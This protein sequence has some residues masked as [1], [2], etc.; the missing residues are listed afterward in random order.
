MAKMSEIKGRLVNA[1]RER[2]EIVNVNIILDY[3]CGYIYL[4]RYA[5]TRKRRAGTTFDREAEVYR[6]VVEGIMTHSRCTRYV[7]RVRGGH[8]R[9]ACAAAY[10]RAPHE[11]S[12][13]HMYTRSR[14]NQA[15]AE[16]KRKFLLRRNGGNEENEENEDWEDEKEGLQ[17]KGVETR[18]RFFSAVRREW[19]KRDVNR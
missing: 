18:R 7:T 2:E 14:D 13:T 16:S 6:R 9:V 11:H 3:S 1:G 8:A 10:K 17:D 4:W 15:R 19:G 5:G 12:R